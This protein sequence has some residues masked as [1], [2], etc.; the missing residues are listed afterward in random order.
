MLQ[1]AEKETDLKSII[2]KEVEA[3]RNKTVDQRLKSSMLQKK[4]KFKNRNRKE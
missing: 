4:R 3:C 2:N 1:L